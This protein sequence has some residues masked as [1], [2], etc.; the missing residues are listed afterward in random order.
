MSTVEEH[1]Q[2]CRRLRAERIGDVVQLT[3]YKSALMCEFRTGHTS[4]VP[5]LT[6]S[7]SVS[8][9][10]SNQKNGPDALHGYV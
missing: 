7:V 3:Q 5:W 1:T 2:V 4:T 9:L 8:R 10:V 6:G